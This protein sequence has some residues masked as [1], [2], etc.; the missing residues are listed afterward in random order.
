MALAALLALKE[1]LE[2]P[3]ALLLMDPVLQELTLLL[4]LRVT[5]ADVEIVRR[6]EAEREGT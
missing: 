2:R 6:A 4:L 3:L 1:T 5:V